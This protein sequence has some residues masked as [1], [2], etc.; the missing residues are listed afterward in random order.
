MIITSNRNQKSNWITILDSH[1]MSGIRYPYIP[2]PQKEPKFEPK[3]TIY[4][5]GQAAFA[6]T[7]VG[8]L[9]ALGKANL[10]PGRTIFGGL[11]QNIRYIPIFA[12]VGT[13]YALFEAVS[14]NLRERNS[15]LNAFVGGAAA[16]GI[17][18]V[19][20]KKASVSK[21]FGSALFLGSFMAVSRW[22][23][24]AAGYGRD[25]MVLGHGEVAEVEKADRQGF[26]EVVHRRPLSQTLEELGDLVRP[27]N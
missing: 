10:G 7:A 11:Q 5:T 3:D 23:G 6:S 27:H 15:P 16:G 12:G 9:V 1:N 4:L 14:C 24:G 25:D 22:A 8:L 19:S 13:A 20:L 26:W 18:G 21:V 17:I 2:S